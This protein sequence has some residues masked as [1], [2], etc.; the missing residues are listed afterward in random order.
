M[1]AVCI[2]VNPSTARPDVSDRT[3]TSVQNIAESNGFD[4]FI[5]C[6]VYPK[7]ATS[8]DD[9]SIKIDTELH[10][11][12][13]KAIEWALR[14]SGENPAV[15]AAWGTLIDLRDYLTDC[16]RDI[17]ELGERMGVQWYTAGSRSKARAHPH[18]PL[19][20]KSDTKLS[21]FDDIREYID[22][23]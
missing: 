10:S 8:I 6:N 20:L 2:G 3:L 15:W 21:P 22:R 23:L 4:S 13:M 16:L 11:E 9:L 5:M 19:Y 18:H 1:S 7:R 12:N 17:V 14:Y